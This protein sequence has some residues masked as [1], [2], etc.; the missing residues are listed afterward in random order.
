MA[1]KNGTNGQSAGQSNG[2]QR[3]RKRPPTSG[4]WKKGQSGNPAG[5]KPKALTIAATT[6]EFL[7]AKGRGDKTRLQELL[8]ALHSAALS[9]HPHSISA[10]RL[11]LDR[12]FGAVRELPPE[13]PEAEHEEAAFHSYLEANPK[14]RKRYVDWLLAEQGEN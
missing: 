1:G 6:R 7:E 14:E 9:G 5:G 12:A 10:A 4:S 13:I 8:D 2:S 3:S 11:L